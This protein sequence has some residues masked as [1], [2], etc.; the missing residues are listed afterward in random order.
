MACAP[1]G[2]EV[3]ALSG[4]PLAKEDV[5]LIVDE[6]VPASEVEA[7]LV[8][9][10]GELLESIALFDVFRGPQI[11]E[12]RKSLAYGLRLRGPDRTLT[13]AEAA[14]ARDGAVRLAVERL[15]AVPREA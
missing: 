5:A 7:T 9:G 2:G 3:T 8:E 11:G 6:R 1:G 10:A 12:G 15:G 14:T 4:F 13:Q